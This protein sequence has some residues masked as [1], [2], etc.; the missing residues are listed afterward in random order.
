MGRRPGRGEAK[1]K[2][3]S[4]NDYG[5]ISLFILPLKRGESPPSL[6]PHRPY[7]YCVKTTGPPTAGPYLRL[8]LVLNRS[9]TVLFHFFSCALA[10]LFHS[11]NKQF[12]SFL[13]PFSQFLFLF[14]VLYSIVDL[15]VLLVNNFS[16][17][18]SWVPSLFILGL[19][20]ARALVCFK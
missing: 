19:W 14:L 9:C 6:H 10:D 5:L 16:P 4:G 3:I 2:A 20:P 13:C 18:S 17:R 1:R 12:P 15:R 8:S 11:F 7:T